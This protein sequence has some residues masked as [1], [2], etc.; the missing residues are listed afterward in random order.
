MRGGG[1]RVAE[2][3]RDR[4]PGRQSRYSVPN[5]LD[6]HLAMSPVTLPQSEEACMAV[7]QQA[8]L[9]KQHNCSNKDCLNAR[10]TARVLK[11]LS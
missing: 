5:P 11:I 2:L 7:C 3:Q 6:L 10:S 9:A 4:F 8:P 1:P